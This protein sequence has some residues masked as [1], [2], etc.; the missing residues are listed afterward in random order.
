MRFRIAQTQQ[1]LDHLSLRLSHPA[2]QLAQAR[3]RLALFGSKLN[4]S[5]ASGLSRHRGRLNRVALGLGRAVPRTESYRGHIRLLAQR[6]RAAPVSYTHLDVYK[7]QVLSLPTNT[8]QPARWASSTGSSPTAPGSLAAV[9]S[10]TPGL[11][12][13]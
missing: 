2:T 3:D 13:R 6:L 12:P 9:T 1:G 11:S 5:L 4:A 8:G 10:A 7:R